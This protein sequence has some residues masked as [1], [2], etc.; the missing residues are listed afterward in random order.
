MEVQLNTDSEEDELVDYESD[1]ETEKPKSIQTVTTKAARHIV[2]EQPNA[3]ALTAEEADFSGT[4]QLL[5]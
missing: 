2:D 5:D 1:N 4:H 3:H